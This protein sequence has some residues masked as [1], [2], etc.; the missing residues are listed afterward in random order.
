MSQFKFSNAQRYAIFL[1][2]GARCYLCGVPLDLTSMVVDHVLP[3]RLLANPTLFEEAK[4]ALGLPATFELDSF[5]NWLPACA[6]CNAKKAAIQFQPSPLI[7]VEL[8]RLAQKAEKARQ[9]CGEIVSARRVSIA[10]G[11]LERAQESGHELG[12]PTRTRLLALL[13]FASERALVPRGQTLHLTPSLGLVMTTVEDALRWG[14]THWSM[15]PRE[16][17]EPAMVVLLRAEQG[18]CA[19]CGLAGRVYQPI[20]QEGG[21]DSICDVC[22]SNIDW[23]PPVTLEALPTHFTET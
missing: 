18:E 16:L 1:A 9:L 8:Q 14:A 11:T 13:E 21:G 12:G 5:E 4:S 3:E 7:Q 20:A 10:L 2:H 22:L 23:T 17:G 15:P 19:E 6:S